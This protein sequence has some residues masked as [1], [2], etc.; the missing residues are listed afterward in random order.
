M[1][2]KDKNNDSQLHLILGCYGR[3]DFGFTSCS[4]VNNPILHIHDKLE[5]YKE[6]IKYLNSVKLFDHR[7]NNYNG[8]RNILFFIQNNFYQKIQPIWAARHFR[9][10]ENFTIQ[11]QSCGI[12][13]GLD[14]ISPVGSPQII[15][16]EIIIEPSKW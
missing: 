2:D 10:I 3:V 5:D 15:E 11:H 8:I 9:L 12:Y 6:I 4:S 14:F 16:K 7:V 13:L 1:Q